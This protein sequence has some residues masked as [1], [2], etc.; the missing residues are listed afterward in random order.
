MQRLIMAATMLL[1]LALGLVG[2]QSVSAQGDPTCADFDT[3]DAAYTAFA[4]AGGPEEDPF[5]LD[6]D[7]DGY[8]CEDIA[9]APA[10]AKTAPEGAWGPTSAEPSTTPS[11]KPSEEPSVEPSAEASVQPS[12]EPSVEPSKEPSVEPSDATGGM[13]TD[14]MPGS[15]VG[16]T[17][18]GSNGLMS[19]MLALAAV[20]AA[21]LGATS[22]LRNRRG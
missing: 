4:D 11:V 9:D 1:A 13:T 18:T 3:Y 19:I 2:V 8:P 5:G 12:E 17:V 16:S 15:G 6:P 14:T 7:R 21:A 20:A 22:L 10:Q